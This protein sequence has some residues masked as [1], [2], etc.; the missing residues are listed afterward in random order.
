MSQSIYDF[1]IPKIDGKNSN[2]GEYKGKTLLIVNVA[3]KC[4]LTP[5][6]AALENIYQQYHN[7]GFEVLGSI[8]NFPSLMF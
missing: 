2:L 5:Q 7:R 1:S 6:Y 4:G 3:S 8:R